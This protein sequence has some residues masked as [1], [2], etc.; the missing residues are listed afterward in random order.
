MYI[1][2]AKRVFSCTML[3]AALCSFSLLQG[4]Q[5]DFSGT[6]KLNESKS[7][8]G[9][10]GARGTAS[11]IVVEQKTDAISVSKTAA[12]FNGEENTST[13]TLTFNGKESETTVF[14]AAK[15]K[16]ILKWADDGKTMTVSYSIAFE[17][18][19]Q[20][21]DIKG[22]ETWSIAADGKTLTVKSVISTPQ[23]EMENKAVYNK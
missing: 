15:K 11:K 20:T 14:G 10:F 17:R 4:L 8:L 16:S 9:Q 3:V 22:T 19:G 18:D 13:E 7:E 12:S 5:T 21:F 23:G 6:W 1:T 2:T